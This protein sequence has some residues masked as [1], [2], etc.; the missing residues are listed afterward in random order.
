MIR[1]VVRIWVWLGIAYVIAVAL[2]KVL[3]RRS[4]PPGAPTGPTGAWPPLAPLPEASPRW[5]EPSDG[6]C[7]ASHPVK[8]KLSSQIFHTPG[9]ASYDRTNPDR[10][11][12]D[13]GAAEADGLRPAKR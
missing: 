6:A 13:A 11:Y 7:P 5:V 10:C 2:N 9:S 3:E 1:R 4:G 12:A 8:A